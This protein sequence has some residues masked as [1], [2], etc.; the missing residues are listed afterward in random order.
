[1]IKRHNPGM[2]RSVFALVIVGVVLLFGNSLFGE[3]NPKVLDAKYEY[4]LKA[5]Y[6]ERFTRFIGWPDEESVSESTKPFVIAIIGTNPFDPYLKELAEKNQ[7]KGRPIEIW[8]VD[9]ITQIGEPEV[10]FISTSQGKNIDKILAFTEGKAML[11]ISESPGFAA[12][13]VHINFYIKREY[14]RF[15]VNPTALRRSGLKPSS[16]FLRLAKIVE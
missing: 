6:L 12:K 10:L 2:V 7:I 16:Q 9:H 15:E 3:D 5:Q 8:F 13:G 11:T 14:V 4:S 1:M